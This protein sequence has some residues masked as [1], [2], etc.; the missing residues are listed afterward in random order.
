MCFSIKYIL[1][2]EVVLVS[3]STTIREVQLTNIAILTCSR[4]QCTTRVLSVASKNLDQHFVTGARLISHYFILILYFNVVTSVT[5]D[6]SQVIVTNCGANGVTSA[7]PKVLHPPMAPNAARIR[8]PDYWIW[9]LIL[10]KLNG[11]INWCCLSVVHPDEVRG[12]GNSSIR[13]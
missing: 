11:L 5:S 9:K 10:Q 6:F 1:F 3:V 7:S 4:V 12:Y 13:G 2:L 8:Y